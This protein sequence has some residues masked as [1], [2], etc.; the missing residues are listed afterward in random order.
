[1]FRIHN[2]LLFLFIITEK[3][4]RVPIQ[5]YRW[6]D[7]R[8]SRIKG[9]YPWTYLYKE[10]YDGEPHPEHYTMEEFRRS[11]SSTT[12]GRRDT[13][14][15]EEL[16]NTSSSERGSVDPI[17][18]EAATPE[19]QQKARP[20]DASIVTLESAESSDNISQYLDKE[21]KENLAPNPE[22]PEES[23]TK[24][25]EPEFAEQGTSKD[26]ASRNERAKSE[27][28][29]RKRKFSIDSS[30]S[31]ISLS[32][33]GVMKK[34][35][36]AK[37]KIKVP[38][39]SFRSLRRPKKETKLNEEETKQ[40]AKETTEKPKKAKKKDSLKQTEPQKPVYIH[41]PLKPPPGETDE[42]SYLEFDETQ[43]KP[44]PSTIQ[45]R[46][47]SSSV[48]D[49]PEPALHDVQFIVLTPPSDDEILED[50]QI[51]ET[52]R[53]S[54]TFFDTSKI[55]ELKT[56][57]KDAA[58]EVKGKKLETLEEV[59][60]NENNK[61]QE[62]L[63]PKEEEETMKVKEE[64]MIVDEEDGLRVSGVAN[65]LGNNELGITIEEVNKE[66][67]DQ[68]ANV[69]ATVTTTTITEIQTTESDPAKEPSSQET[70][71]EAV[72]DQTQ[73]ISEESS[74]KQEQTQSATSSQGAE[75]RKSF[76]KKGN[77][78]ETERIYEDVQVPKTEAIETDNSNKTSSDEKTK[79]QPGSITQSMSVDEEKAY[80][81][82]KIMKNTSL[83]EDYNKWSK[84]K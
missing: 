51:P 4:P 11:K 21:E 57:A 61:E 63:P 84:I 69:S 65:V 24:L 49:S 19:P 33:L 5:T 31:R 3:P 17:I 37:E 41:I 80:L 47:E 44:K 10:P 30:Y 64:A 38:R 78:E 75:K 71:K 6:E 39:L 68:A 81:D 8:K 52:P 7:L 59:K 74:Q 9:G 23:P 79:L 66:P 70:V 82:A 29:K 62:A 35:R 40:E 1:M 26:E 67:T 36:D 32:K 18:T 25:L 43:T 27:E 16:A 12:L 83:E 20:R 13:L 73:D 14:E 46:T 56:L 15:I 50:I 76:R 2:T 72:A 55:E 45:E 22:N 42:F 77:K 58:D 54:E 60:E 53:G 34:L 48:P 28:P